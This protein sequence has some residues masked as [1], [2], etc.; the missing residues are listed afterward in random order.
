MAGASSFRVIRGVTAALSLCLAMWTFGEPANAQTR[1][2]AIAVEGNL[3]IP[4][5]TIISLADL[6]SGA[7]AS[8]AQ[9]NDAVQRIINSGLFETVNVAPTGGG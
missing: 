5:S 2:S 4:A 9:I 3:R 8:D 7:V 6:E 1:V